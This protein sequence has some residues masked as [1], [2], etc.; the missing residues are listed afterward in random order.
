MVSEA[1]EEPQDMPGA[2]VFKHGTGGD[3]TQTLQPSKLLLNIVTVV[4]ELR[5]FA[6]LEVKVLMNKDSCQIGPKDWITIARELH[7]QRDHFD[8]FIVVHGTDTM[9]YTASAI[10]LMLSGK[11]WYQMGVFGKMTILSSVVLGEMTVLTWR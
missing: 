9:S 5:T 3:Y 1:F 6:N 10:S 7:M 4:P 11:V 8:A 2:I